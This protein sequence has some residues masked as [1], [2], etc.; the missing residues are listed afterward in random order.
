ML[1]IYYLLYFIISTAVA[2]NPRKTCSN[3]GLQLEG[4]IIE[5]EN[6]TKPL[7][8]ALDGI[9]DVAVATLGIPLNSLGIFILCRRKNRPLFLSLMLCLF[10][11]DSL[12]LVTTILTK[13]LLIAINNEYVI[14]TI[15]FLYPYFSHPVLHIAVYSSVWLTVLMSYERYQALKN[16]IEYSHKNRMPNFQ[17][18]RVLTNI[19][20]VGLFSTIFNI[21]KFLEYKTVDVSKKGQIYIWEDKQP[22]ISSKEK[23]DEP[24]ITFNSS[25]VCPFV[26]ETNWTQNEIFVNYLFWS[27]FILRGILPLILLIFFNLNIFFF[28]KR[29]NKTIH[30]S[31][32]TSHENNAKLQEIKMAKIFLS[33]VSAFIVCYAFWYVPKIIKAFDKLLCEDSSS[34]DTDDGVPYSVCCYDQMIWYHII[35]YVGNILI[36]LNSSINLVLYGLTGETFKK[37]AKDVL[38]DFV[39]TKCSAFTC[40]RRTGKPKLLSALFST[41]ETEMVE[42][43][44]ESSKFIQTP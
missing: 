26:K 8:Y 4:G 21:E 15:T 20:I 11:I 18:K 2:E 5:L 24:P 33:I 36:T 3:L 14:V 10:S 6:R 23:F 19:F 22:W 17:K 25:D 37:D 42:L 41:V 39:H 43:P 29:E 9:L 32:G 28:I 34:M 1:H 16:P 35:E 40:G 44:R 27:D 7:R 12:V 38:N 13:S 31:L 30:Q